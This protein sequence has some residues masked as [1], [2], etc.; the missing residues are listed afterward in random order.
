V[1]AIDSAPAAITC[2][3]LPPEKRLACRRQEARALQRQWLTTLAWGNGTIS[4]EQAARIQLWLGIFPVNWRQLPDPSLLEQQLTT[5]GRHQSGSYAALLS[6]MVLDPALQLS[7]NGPANHRRNPNEN[8]ARELLELFSLG[9]GHY[10]EAD[11]REAARALSGYRLSANRQLELD[12][13]RHDPGPKTILG[14]TAAFD[15]AS[16]AAWLAE[17]PA[18]A[19]PITSRLWL[20][21][22]GTPPSPQR[23]E[24]LASGWRQQQLA[25]P[26]L[27]NAIATSPEAI[28]SRQQGLRLADPLEVVARSLRLLGSRHP[29]A[30]AISLDGLRS[31]GQAPF[32]PPS[33]KG[34]PHNAQWLNLRWLQARR[35]SLQALLADEE[36]WSS[37]QLPA[38]LSAGLTPIPTL[39]LSLPAAASRANL[40]ALFADPVWQLA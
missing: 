16:L 37:A 24:A 6:A 20:Q 39:A 7:L 15:G 14:R 38:Q 35:R 31:M 32:E 5:I 26:W 18:T 9:E 13:R 3:A 23:L 1:T 4:A 10:S 30:L 29:D 36:V 12:P 8:L 27:F 28:R 2:S 21:L 17:Q 40:S 25:I 19:R 34:W 11:V 22:V 33:V